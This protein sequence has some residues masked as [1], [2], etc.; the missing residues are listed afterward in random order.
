MRNIGMRAS[1]IVLAVARACE[2]AKAD[3]A[4]ALESD[5]RQ[6]TGYAYLL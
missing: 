1:D 6:L 4:V 3:M 2:Q 5:L